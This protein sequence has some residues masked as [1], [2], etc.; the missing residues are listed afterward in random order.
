MHCMLSYLD[1]LFAQ[2]INLDQTWINSAIEATKLCN[3]TDITLRNRS[4]WVGAN[5]AA[6]NS[7]ES[8]NTCT[9]SIHCEL[10]E[11]E[12]GTNQRSNVLMLP[13]QPWPP[14]SLSPT[15]VCA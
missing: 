4:V 10:L 11:L 14:W 5:D 13:Y 1:K 7:S 3:Q 6:R 8:T 12:I 9:K 15:R 2:R